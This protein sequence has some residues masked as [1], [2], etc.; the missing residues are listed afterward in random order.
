MSRTCGAVI[1]SLMRCDL[2][3]AIAISPFKQIGNP[4]KSKLRRDTVLLSKFY[5]LHINH[6]LRA[7]IFFAPCLA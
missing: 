1:I 7:K 2:S 3:C 5:R 4:Y 6:M